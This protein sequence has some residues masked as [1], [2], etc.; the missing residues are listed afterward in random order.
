MQRLLAFVPLLGVLG[1]CGG[2]VL[3][4][5]LDSQAD[6]GPSSVVLPDVD[7]SPPVTRRD[8]GTRVDTGVDTGASHDAGR[9]TPGTDAST[10]ILPYA[11]G[12]CYGEVTQTPNVSCTQS[13][14]GAGEMCGATLTCGDLE[15]TMQC[16]GGVCQCQNPVYG[17]YACSCLAPSS[18]PCGVASNCCWQ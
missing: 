15:L 13:S 17:E 14:S 7:A 8:A 1:G 16:A 11:P 10:V 4:E 3:G 6:S 2:L 9:I 18:D 5:E 12:A